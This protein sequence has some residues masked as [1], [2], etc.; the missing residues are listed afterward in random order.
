MHEQPMTRRLRRALE[1]AAKQEALRQAAEKPRTAEQPSTV[2]PFEELANDYLSFVLDAYRQ[3]IV[4]AQSFAK[5]IAQV[6]ERLH[7]S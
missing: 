2:L 5:Q 1:A 6:G 4:A 3:T 7:S